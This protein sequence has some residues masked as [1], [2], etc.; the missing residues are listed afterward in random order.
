[1]RPVLTA[2][3]MRAVDAHLIAMGVP[4]IVLMENA[5]RGAAHLIGLRD[6]PRSPAPSHAA[7]STP[8]A[9]GLGGSCVRC[10]DERALG[11]L[12][13]AVVCGPGNNGGDGSVVARHLLARGAAVELFLVADEQR[14]TADAQLA[15]AAFVAVGGMVHDGRQAPLEQQLAQ[16]GL[17]VDAVLGIGGKRAPEGE[18]EAA[19]QA[20]NACTRPVVALD[21]PSGLD[22]TTGARAGACVVAEHTVTF[23]FLKTG[24]LT[25]SGFSAGGRVTVTQ[26]GVPARLPEGIEPTVF[27]LEEADVRANLVRRDPAVHKVQAGRVVIVGGSA[28]MTGAPNLAG[29]AALRA[30]AGL[31]TIVLPPAVSWGQ[32]GE[33]PALMTRNSPWPPLDETRELIQNAD[34]LVI[35]PGLGRTADA[36]ERTLGALESGHPTVLDADGLRVMVGDVARLL[37]HPALVLTPHPGEAA[38]LLGMTAA[39]VEADRFSAAR[40]L[41]AESGAIVLLKGPRTLIAEPNGSVCVSAFG[42]PALATA[43]S[44][45]V[46]AGLIAG[47]LAGNRSNV[48]REDLHRATLLGVGLHGLAAELWS[49]TGGDA[50]LLA[51]DLIDLLPQVRA[52]LLNELR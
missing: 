21:V 20:I 18:I 4:G 41:A 28:G 50:G 47:L 15:L 19:I 35:G 3:E 17:V 31:V 24:L 45:D 52:R 27:L 51:T 33:L 6:R 9:R 32:D 42:T 7:R 26:L 22:A 25:T 46:L 8:V 2:S 14:L 36:K 1:M 43:G 40:R 44:G 48:T 34:A 37:A 5:G 13:I 16:F 23:G 38:D 10:A 30:G 39:D 11:G 29:R 12:R 49:E